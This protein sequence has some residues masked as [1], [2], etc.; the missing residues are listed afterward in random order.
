MSRVKICKACNG[1]GEVLVRE[2][3]HRGECTMMPCRDCKGSGKVY[4]RKFTITLPF[5]NKLS[6][7]YLEAERNILSEINKLNKSIQ[8]NDD[9]DIHR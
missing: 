7:A 5:D 6:P 4:V 8:Y 3:G 1:E 9:N 2:P